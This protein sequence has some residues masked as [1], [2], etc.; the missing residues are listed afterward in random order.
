M[1]TC[2]EEINMDVLKKVK[3]YFSADGNLVQVELYGGDPGLAYRLPATAFDVIATKRHLLQVGLDKRFAGTRSGDGKQSD[4]AVRVAASAVDVVVKPTVV[5]VGAAV[6]LE[7]KPEFLEKVSVTVNLDDR[8]LIESIN[9]ESSRDIAG[10]ISLVGKALPLAA[11]FTTGLALRNSG[12]DNEPKDLAALWSRSHERL[13]LHRKRLSDQADAML[14]DLGSPGT[15][16]TDTRE[17]GAALAVLQEQLAA[18][19]RVRREWLVAAL[20]EPTTVRPTLLTDDCVHVPDVALPEVLLGDDMQV[21][22]AGPSVE[23]AA[24]YGVRLA[25]ADPERPDGEGPLPPAGALEDV[26]LVRRARPVQLGLYRRTGNGSGPGTWKLDRD[27]VTYL[28]VVDR[29]SAIDGISIDGSIL[30]S[31][32]F[33]LAFHADKS[34]K[35]FGMASESAVSAISASLGGVADVVTTLRKEASKPPAEQRALDKAQTQLD[36]LKV[37]SE[38]EQLSATVDR[39]AELAALEQQRRL[40]ELGSRS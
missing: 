37:T 17:V 32:K 2:S 39:A 8:G 31:K 1:S 14:E 33:E 25:L 6:V 34:V 11:T 5:P 12:N 22:D 7:V 16:A 26:I 15:S 20:P 30:R 28:D 10:V 35:T 23:L 19:G 27:S 36:L 4:D 3:K 18:I 38:M 24:E 29:Y 21:P 9:S 13:E 40:E